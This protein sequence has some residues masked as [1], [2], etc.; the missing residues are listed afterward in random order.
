MAFPHRKLLFKPSIKLTVDAKSLTC[1]CCEHGNEN[2]CSFSYSKSCPSC[3][4]CCPPPPPPPPLPR[5]LPPVVPLSR[6][7][8]SGLRELAIAALTILA[9]VIIAALL[10]CILCALGRAFYLRRSR[11]RGRRDPPIIFGTQ[12]DFF[13]EDRGPQLDHHI[14]YITTVGL[15]QSVI[16]SIAVFKYKSYD[17]LIDGTECSVCLTEF[18]E[19]ESLRLLPKCSHAFH[20]PC[21]DTWLRSHKNCPLCRAPIISGV[22]AQG[23]ELGSS[24]RGLDLRHEN[25]GEN[26]GNYGGEGSSSDAGEGESSDGRIGCD[27]SRAISSDE[28]A[29][30]NSNKGLPLKIRNGEFDSRVLSDLTDNRRVVEGDLQPMRRSVSLDSSSAVMIYNDVAG[31]VV[32]DKQNSTLNSRMNSKNLKSKSASKRSSGS[33][34]ITKLMKS[35]SIGIGTSLQKGPISMKRSWSS[36]G[37]S[38]SS[39]H[40][41]RHSILSL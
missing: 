14:W 33:S 16:D 38:S 18:Q 10:F 40:T 20:M 6:D 36:G 3:V 26:L 39:R 22:V 1:C 32:H 7:P 34:G 27:N 12:E 5:R 11:S 2:K 15:P 30:E 31:G 21:I 28:D 24:S 19:D 8:N 4:K 25:V 41:R 29:S 9:C 23:S 37:K 13:D 35:A 17:G